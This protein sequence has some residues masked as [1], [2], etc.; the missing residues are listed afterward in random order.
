MK[1]LQ[2]TIY[3]FLVLPFLSLLQLLECLSWY[4]CV[5]T[6]SQWSFHRDFHNY[7]GLNRLVNSFSEFTIV[8][9]NKLI[10]GC[11]PQ[12]SAKIKKTKKKQKKTTSCEK[13]L[14][15]VALRKSFPKNYTKFTKKPVLE[16]LSNTV[17][18]L[19]TVRLATL[20]TLFRM[21]GWWG[22]RG[23]AKRLPLPVFPL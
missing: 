17:K 20:L 11:K 5:A 9:P 7:T 3:R 15:G 1:V 23:G 18:D 8:P 6:T 22:M 16:S 19:H 21:D 10:L 2:S 13:W 12:W 14:F 4:I